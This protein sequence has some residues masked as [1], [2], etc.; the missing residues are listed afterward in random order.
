LLH[1]RR[2]GELVSEKKGD[3]QDIALSE[4]QLRLI[5]AVVDS[6]KLVVLVVSGV[7]M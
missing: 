3:I 2:R 1:R 7:L 6:K 5:D 4:L